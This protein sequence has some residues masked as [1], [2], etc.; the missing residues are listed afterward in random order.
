M[1]YFVKSKKSCRELVLLNNT[2][3]SAGVCVSFGR[4]SVL[5]G[6]SCPHE[7]IVKKRAESVY[8]ARK[9]KRGADRTQSCKNPAAASADRKPR[10]SRPAAKSG[11]AA[12]IL[13]WDRTFTLSPTRQR[14]RSLLPARQG[15]TFFSHGRENPLPF[16]QRKMENAFPQRGKKR[17]LLPAR[18]GENI[19]FARQGKTRFPFTQREME[20]AF[21]QRGEEK[22]T[23]SLRDK[24]KTF[25]SHGKERAEKG[26]KGKTLDKYKK[27]PYTD[28][29]ER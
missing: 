2:G 23:S 12:E 18:Q 3:D 13:L 4:H 24:G 15:E 10:F 28:T 7:N 6:F 14:K 17:R 16:T 8:A 11:G 27:M 25:F 20:N 9:K 19:L 21:P 1:E 5:Q 26:Q 22:A 29:E